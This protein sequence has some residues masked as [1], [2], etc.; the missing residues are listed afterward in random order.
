[1]AAEIGRRLV[2]RPGAQADH[3]RGWPGAVDDPAGVRLRVPG[4]PAFGERRPDGG[5]HAGD[6][7]SS[8]GWSWRCRLCASRSRCPWER[9]VPVRRRWRLPV[10]DVVQTRYTGGD[11]A[12]AHEWGVFGPTRTYQTR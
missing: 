1:P 4:P 2:D 8:A 12:E 10:D 3:V 5:A 7:S 9:R 6:K 11:A